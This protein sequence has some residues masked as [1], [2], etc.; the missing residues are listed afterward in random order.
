MEG[1]RRRLA[2]LPVGQRALVAI[3]GAPGS[4][5]STLAE[6]LTISL[7]R[8]VPDRAAVLPMDGYHYDNLVLT[9]MSRSD[10]KGAPDTFDVLGLQQMLTRLK[11]NA[12]DSVA[13]PVFD[14]SLDMARAAAR[15]VRKQTDLILVEG[16]YLLCKAPP[17]SML[18]PF[19]QLTVLIDAPEP[20]LR[21]RL[22]SRWLDLGL[23]QVEARA[24][25]QE[26]DM[27]NGAYVRDMSV[28]PDFVLVADV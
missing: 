18:L 19:F 5:K 17:W 24:R 10:R 11:S 8:E 21:T 13:V 16:N 9:A 14:R 27:P 2:G 20:L 26:N 6:E 1:L 4:G 25:V 28:R 22:M 7:N 15:L 3:A 23:S 12:E